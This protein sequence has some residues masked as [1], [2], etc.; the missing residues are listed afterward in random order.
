[1]EHRFSTR[2][3]ATVLAVALVSVLNPVW[4]DATS[5]SLAGRILSE[6]ARTPLSGAVIQLT[7]PSDEVVK[8]DPTTAEGMFTLANLTPGV[9][10]CVVETRDGMYQVTSSLRL[11]PG[12]SRSIQLA[13]KKEQQPIAAGV[14]SATGGG[15]GGGGSAS[16]YAP[17]IGIGVIL[18]T[19]GLAA[20]LDSDDKKG[21]PS[22]PED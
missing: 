6:D 14:G 15:A 19:L 9:Y 1:M 8:S 18:G 10:R 22:S 4:A 11:E 2:F 13:L 3:L 12:Q 17:L 21:S 16:A 5:A 7:G 20:V